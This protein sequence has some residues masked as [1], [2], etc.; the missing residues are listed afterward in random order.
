M[1]RAWLRLLKCSLI[2]VRSANIQ[3]HAKQPILKAITGQKKRHK[4]VVH[5]AIVR[6]Q[7]AHAY[8]TIKQQTMI[9][10]SVGPKCTE[11]M[12]SAVLWRSAYHNTRIYIHTISIHIYIYI[13]YILW[14]PIH[15]I[16]TPR[17]QAGQS[18]SPQNANAMYIHKAPRSHVRL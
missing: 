11:N 15:Q 17:L 4:N 9:R 16:Y 5:P 6:G 10:S 12:F 14:M 2:G 13:V 18:A 1:T 7:F 8:N 3:T